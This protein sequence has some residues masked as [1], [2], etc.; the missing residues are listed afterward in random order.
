MKF[1]EISSENKIFSKKKR[2]PEAAD[3][4]FH[5]FPIVLSDGRNTTKILRPFLFADWSVKF[6]EI[7]SQNDLII[8]ILSVFDFFNRVAGAGRGC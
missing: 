8:A 2:W 5:I 4:G 7:S 3:H 6:V 1:F